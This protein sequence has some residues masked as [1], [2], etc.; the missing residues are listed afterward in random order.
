MD[1]VGRPKHCSSHSDH[2]VCKALVPHQIPNSPWWMLRYPFSPQHSGRRF[3]EDEIHVAPQGRNCPPSWTRWCL[4]TQSQVAATRTRWKSRRRHPSAFATTRRCRSS[5]R[6]W[7]S[8]S[9][10]R[11]SQR[12]SRSSI[13]FRF[14][15][16]VMP[17]FPIITRKFFWKIEGLLMLLDSL[18]VLVE[19]QEGLHKL[20]VSK[21]FSHQSH[22]EVAHR[23]AAIS[24]KVEV[25]LASRSSI[26]QGLP[27][28]WGRSQALQQVFDTMCVVKFHRGPAHSQDPSTFPPAFV[29]QYLRFSTGVARTYQQTS[30]VYLLHDRALPSHAGMVC[31]FSEAIA[32]VAEWDQSGQQRAQ[33]VLLESA[34]RNLP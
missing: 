8:S 13:R 18:L 2:S 25:L 11:R 16:S 12:W 9:S 15:G 34:I 14:I 5:H 23:F 27:H 20:G 6:W 10:R 1:E 24:T 30:L 3:V 7:S 21:S 26:R 4:K 31:S 28:Q 22:Q 19:Q 33:A 29:A 32:K 17:P